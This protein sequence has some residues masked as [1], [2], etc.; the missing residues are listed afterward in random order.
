MTQ[1]EEHLGSVG[2]GK[3]KF[4]GAIVRVERQPR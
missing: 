3:P 2:E 4:G 1:L